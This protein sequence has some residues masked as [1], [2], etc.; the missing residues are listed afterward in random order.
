MADPIKVLVVDDI[1]QNLVVLQ[2]LLER[3]GLELLCAH[4]GAE[5]LELLLTHSVALALLDVHMPAMDGFEL[6]ELMR[7]SPRTRQVPIIFLTAT[8]RNAMRTF[9]GYDAGAVDFL[10]KPFDPHILRSKVEVFVKLFAGQRQLAEQNAAL[11]EALR[12]NDMFVAV[13]GHDLR[14]PLAAMMNLAEI[15]HRVGESEKVRSA[16]QRISQS[17]QRM[18]R[19]IEQM[20]DL[21]MVRAG[22]VTLAPVDMDMRLLCEQIVGEF[23]GANTEQQ[24]ELECIGA[25]RGQWDP[26]RLGQVL[27]NLIGNAVQYG[28]GSAVHVT[29]DGSVAESLRVRVSNAGHIAQE[30]IERLFEPFE[31][32]ERDGASDGYG[33]GLFIVH[34]LVTLH[35]GTI[36]VHSQGGQTTFEVVLPKRPPSSARAAR[37]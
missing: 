25:T 17:G 14:N 31:R 7:G 1:E 23:A 30:T 2:A 6:A 11:Q 12:M 18:A 19:L 22:R 26:D 8:D 13:L 3:P 15:V 28:V 35:H 36:G 34:E 29:V 21:A 5:A 10:Y 24:L 27:S 37:I 9:R 4:S 16:G 20:L 33:L 32:G